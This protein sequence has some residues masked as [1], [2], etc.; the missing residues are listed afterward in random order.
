MKY[1]KKQFKNIRIFQDK[2]AKDFEYTAFALD[3]KE[4]LTKTRAIYNQVTEE[5]IYLIDWLK[6]LGIK[7]EEL[8]FEEFIGKYSKPSKIWENAASHEIEFINRL[9]DSKKSIEEKTF[10]DYL[11]Y[12]RANS[13]IELKDG[14]LFDTKLGLFLKTDYDTYESKQFNSEL[15][16]LITFSI[17]GTND[18][19]LIQKSYRF[20]KDFL[21]KHQAKIVDTLYG[22][23]K[24][25]REEVYNGESGTVVYKKRQQELIQA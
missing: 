20:F 2:E 17:E 16:E 11:E 10:K 18:I 7:P 23:Y 19:M 4:Y 8:K 25:Y 1:D 21:F 15:G 24:T 13:E 12:S 6:D 9:N 22:L 5:K 3:Q 14:F